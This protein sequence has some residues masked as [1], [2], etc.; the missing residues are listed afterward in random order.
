LTSRPRAAHDGQATFVNAVCEGKTVKITFLGKD[1]TPNDSPTLYATDR[2]TF[3]VQGYVVTDPEA[4][5]QMRIPDGETVV[6]VPKR[7]MKYLP[8]DAHAEGDG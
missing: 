5:S 2:E 6:E 3:L 4:L 7:L 1:S 8:E